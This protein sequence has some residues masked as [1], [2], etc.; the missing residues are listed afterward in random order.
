MAVLLKVIKLRSPKRGNPMKYLNLAL[1][2]L[3]KRRWMPYMLAKLV[4]LLRA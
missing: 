3:M 4:I 2:I 1:C